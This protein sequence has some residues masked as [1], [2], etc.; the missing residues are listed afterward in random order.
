MAR[1]SRHF[2]IF[3]PSRLSLATGGLLLSGLLL[4]LAR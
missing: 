1:A 2:S 4:R 3:A